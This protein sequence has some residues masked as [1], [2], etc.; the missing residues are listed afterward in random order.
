MPEM[1]FS[2]RWP[3]G[4]V[5]RCYSPSYVVEEY[6]EVGRDYSVS[7]FLDRVRKSLHIASERV[8]ERYGMGC[9]AAL[10]Q[11]AQIEA[12]GQSLPPEQRT[13]RVHVTSFEKHPPRDARLSARRS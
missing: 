1:H 10:D 7:E 11:L 8:R 9:S 3:S 12:L 4:E 5:S 6:L 2:V 13:G